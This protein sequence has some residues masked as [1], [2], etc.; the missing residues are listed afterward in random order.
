MLILYINQDRSP[1]AHLI[2]TAPQHLQYSFEQNPFATLRE[3][4]PSSQLNHQKTTKI[5][6]HVRFGAKVPHRCR[7]RSHAHQ[8]SSP[9]PTSDAGISKLQTSAVDDHLWNIGQKEGIWPSCSAYPSRNDALGNQRACSWGYGAEAC[10]RHD[11][12][13]WGICSVWRCEG[14]CW[15]SYPSGSEG[16]KL[17]ERAERNATRGGRGLWSEVNENV[18]ENPIYYRER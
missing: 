15:F 9:D 14:G 18:V 4:K 16:W 11:W 10:W 7:N 3:K 8:P 2:S 1:L 13:T 12:A 6:K 5:Q 17:R